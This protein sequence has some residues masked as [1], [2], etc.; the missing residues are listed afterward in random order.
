MSRTVEV[1]VNIFSAQITAC[2]INFGKYKYIKS[3]CQALALIITES[4]HFW[5]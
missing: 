3:G 1:R 5:V 4:S 2:F